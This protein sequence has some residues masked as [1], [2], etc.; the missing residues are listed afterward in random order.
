MVPDPEQIPLITMDKGKGS[1]LIGKTPVILSATEFAVLSILLR[2]MKEGNLLQRWDEIDPE[3]NNLMDEKDAPLN[4][5]WIHDFQENSKSFNVEDARKAASRIRGK[6]KRVVGDPALVAL[7]LPSFK[8]AVS[9]TYP[10]A[11]IR[12][13][14]W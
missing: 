2:R 11:K 10:P 5:V 9:D 6:L 12:I 1:L 7:I 8:T 13:I 14:D 3:L 4:V